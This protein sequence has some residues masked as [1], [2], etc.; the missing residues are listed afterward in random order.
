MIGNI[1]LAIITPLATCICAF[2]PKLLEAKLES[3]K[4]KLQ[5]TVIGVLNQEYENEL[6]ELPDY[7]DISKALHS[8]K[9]KVYLHCKT[10]S[11]A[12]RHCDF[13]ISDNVRTDPKIIT[14]TEASV[15]LQE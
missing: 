8:K 14:S 11:Y 1:L 7:T 6:P 13:V 5:V 15:I 12:L 10:L 4:R 3:K 2:L 9:D